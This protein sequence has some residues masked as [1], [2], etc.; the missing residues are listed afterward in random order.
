MWNYIKFY[1][2][3]NKFYV[4]FCQTKINNFRYS[5]KNIKYYLQRY[6]FKN[7]KIVLGNTL[8]FIVDPSLEHP[9]LADRLKVICCCY[10]IAKTNHFNFK[11]IFETPF[12]LSDYLVPNKVDWKASVNDLSYS[13][14]NSRLLAYNGGGKIPKLNPK[15]K[16][17]HIY[18]YIGKN[19]LQCNNI[20]NWEEIWRECYQE[21]F[22]PS[23]YLNNLLSTQNIIPKNYIA[24]HLRFVNALGNFEKG[25]YNKISEDQRNRLINKCLSIIDEIKNKNSKELIIFSD[26]SLFL[27]HAVQHGYKTLNGNIGHISYCQDHSIFDKVFIDFY[28][29][30][31]ADTVYRIKT[32]ELYNTTFSYYASL[33]NGAKFININE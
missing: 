4:N 15:I 18:H 5:I 28:A 32:K 6:T 31:L 11:I 22:K 33:A 7:D 19:I 14:Q 17:Y 16:P 29:I 27:G 8:Y 30:G 20:K 12:I 2:R 1:L 3:N 23:E 25:F 9:G 21:L 26:S 24:V 10:Y 13:L